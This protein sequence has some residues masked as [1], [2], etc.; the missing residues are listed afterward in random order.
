[1]V[2]IL[3]YIWNIQLKVL[4]REGN[5]QIINIANLMRLMLRKIG[6]STLGDSGTR[7]KKWQFI[8]SQI[9]SYKFR[10]L[11]NQL[12]IDLQWETKYTNR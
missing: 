6:T 9:E 5:T 1:M 11:L 12:L 2:E 10:D 4:K 8:K 7:F 3:G